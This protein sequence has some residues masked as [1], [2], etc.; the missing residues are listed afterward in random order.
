MVEPRGMVFKNEHE[1]NGEKWYSY[2]FSVSAKNQNGEWESASVPIRFVKTIVKPDNKT[3]VILRDW[4]LKPMKFK[5][6]YTMG[7]FCKDYEVVGEPTD[8]VQGFTAI[9]DEDIPF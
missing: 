4:W 2:N 8:D 6:G 7:I 9:V 1:T 3:R 5:D